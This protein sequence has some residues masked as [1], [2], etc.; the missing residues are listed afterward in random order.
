MPPNQRD[1]A[2]HSAT[3]GALLAEQASLPLTLRRIA[4]LFLAVAILTIGHGLQRT[5]LEIRAGRRWRS[6]GSFGLV[7]S[8]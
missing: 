8:A 3:S 5:L 4:P 1:G 6:A 7:M 2:R